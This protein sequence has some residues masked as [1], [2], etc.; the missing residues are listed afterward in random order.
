ML[1]TKPFYNGKN[2]VVFKAV[3]TRNKKILKTL[4]ETIIG[5]EV[6]IEK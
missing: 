5:E 3:M 2:D 1:E 4:I 6:I